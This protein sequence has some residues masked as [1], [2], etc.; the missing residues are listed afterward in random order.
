MPGK[1]TPSQRRRADDAAAV[2]AATVAAGGEPGSPLKNKRLSYGRNDA[3]AAETGKKRGPP[4]RRT[5]ASDADRSPASSPVKKAGQGGGPGRGQGRKQGGGGQS[6]KPVPLVDGPSPPSVA[7]P[8]DI[9]AATPAATP[10]LVAT[11]GTQGSKWTRY[12]ASNVPS[13]AA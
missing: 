4:P 7:H 3:S 5:V 12:V 10:V 9:P 11:P 1:P 13:V 6:F 2:A 8:L